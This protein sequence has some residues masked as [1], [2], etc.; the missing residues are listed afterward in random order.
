MIAQAQDTAMIKHWIKSQQLRPTMVADRRLFDRS[1]VEAL[2]RHKFGSQPGK[3]LGA[4]RDLVRLAMGELTVQGGC[5]VETGRCVATAGYL[6]EELMDL[7]CEADREDPRSFDDWAQRR[8][9]PTAAEIMQRLAIFNWRRLLARA[10]P[11]QRP[12]V[13]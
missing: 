9:A 5:L 13:A 4:R 3:L 7:V 11:S 1:A 8:G 12:L 6:D 10:R 2:L